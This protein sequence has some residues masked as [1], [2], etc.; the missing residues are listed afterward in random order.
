MSTCISNVTLM[1]FTSLFEVSIGIHLLYSLFPGIQQ[2][3]LAKTSFRQKM[4]RRAIEGC[5]RRK[6]DFEE[7]KEHFQSENK[8]NQ[9]D[10][11]WKKLSEAEREEIRNRR[12]NLNKKEREFNK[13]QRAIDTHIYD[14]DLELRSLEQLLSKKQ[15]K[16]ILFSLF[17]VLYSLCLIIIAGFFP[18]FQ[19]QWIVMVPMIM[20]SILPMPLMLLSIYRASKSYLTK[21]KI[22]TEKLGAVTYHCAMG[23]FGSLP[24][25]GL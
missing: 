19:V 2:I 11:N 17:V 5:Q 20:L 12:V 10:M 25:N 18:N 4:F 16:F 14:Y 13:I 24:N 3:F 21:A 1:N 8:K 6:R 9:V 7:D 22:A 23:T 15:N